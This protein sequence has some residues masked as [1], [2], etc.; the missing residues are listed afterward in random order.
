MAGR[1]TRGAA[2]AGMVLVLLGLTGCSAG[3]AGAAQNRSPEQVATDFVPLAESVVAATGTAGWTFEDSRPWAAG[4]IGGLRGQA[5]TGLPGKHTLQLLLLGQPVA[6][7]EA[8]VA[9][10]RKHLEEH[11]FTIS[12]QFTPDSAGAEFTVSGQR[13]DG[14]AVDYRASVAGQTLDL[15]SECSA[16]IELNQNVPVGP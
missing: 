6:D 13:P 12:G 7:A 5:C 11:D 16:A 4:D 1:M 14:A 3:G 9:A 15:E 10:M 2:R 8:A